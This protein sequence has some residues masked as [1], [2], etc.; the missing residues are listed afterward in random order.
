MHGMTRVRSDRSTEAVE[1]RLEIQYSNLNAADVRGD[2][3]ADLLV[4]IEA[5]LEV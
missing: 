2:T 4:N 3:L 5:D 1:R